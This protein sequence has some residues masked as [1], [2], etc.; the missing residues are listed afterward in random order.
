MQL[1]QERIT[2]QSGNI[3]YKAGHI[4]ESIEEEFSL[5]K[6][7]MKGQSGKEKSQSGTVR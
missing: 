1:N 2:S 7:R 5:N 6:E 3:E 4:E